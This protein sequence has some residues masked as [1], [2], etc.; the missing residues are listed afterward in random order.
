MNI[1]ETFKNDWLPDDV[2]QELLN[3][4]KHL[5]EASTQLHG[6]ALTWANAEH[7]Y[8][9]AKAKALIRFKTD[10]EHKKST[11]QYL[12]ALIDEECA[13]QRLAAYIARAQKEAS[14]ELVRSIRAQLNA[15]QSIGANV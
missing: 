15:L 6:N 13:S 12:E 4:I 10:E 7:N 11:V 2:N 5:S 3:L 14:L 9:A 8:R 1:S